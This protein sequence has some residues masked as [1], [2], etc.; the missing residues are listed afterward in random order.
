LDLKDE[1][2]ARSSDDGNPPSAA[3][4]APP[5]AAGEVAIPP[6]EHFIPIRKS[7]LLDL[8]CREPG[9]SDVDRDRFRRL[10]QILSSTFHLEYHAK[11]ESLKDAYAAFDPDADT[12]RVAAPDGEQK[13]TALQSLMGEFVW[14]LERANFRRLT[15][16]SIL[17]AMRESSFWGVNLEVDFD[18]FDELEVFSRGE[19]IQTRPLPR[20]WAHRL[21]LPAR[22]EVQVPVFQRLVLMLRL[23]PGKHV[24]S[25]VDT[26]RV[27]IKVFKDI[28]K[29]DL[30][31]LLPGTRVNMN[32][33]DRLKLGLS[34]STG[35]GMTG[36]KVAGPLLGLAAGVVNPIAA[37]GVAGGAVG[38]GVR[39]F[40]GYL[41]TKQ[42]YQLTLAQS[43]YFL[44]LDNN[45]G[46]LFRLLDEA[47]E[48]ECREAMLAYYV[49]WREPRD[50][51]WTEPEL[52]EHVEQYLK[53][54]A[55]VDVDFEVD[56]AVAKLKRLK[57]VDEP[58]PGR[59]RAVPIDRALEALDYAWD[60]HFNHNRTLDP[61]PPAT[62]GA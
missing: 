38:F 30:E 35:L 18:V 44:N 10:Y 47:E 39:Q 11:L 31:M 1:T 61:V 13:Q 29:M 41:S 23:K 32:L 8:L 57:L 36:Y 49:L 6:R 7:D 33:W 15:R 2:P 42:K 55:G 54:A 45:T 17:A 4:T 48:Q 22:T 34:L 43:L 25:G 28:P 3:A 14:L 27:H 59:L 62:G 5:S 24:P 51:G 40:M 50:A 53:R 60:N 19:T 20:S 46:V 58:S 21:R 52:D 16:E 26:S 9:M 56:D 37:L 12:K